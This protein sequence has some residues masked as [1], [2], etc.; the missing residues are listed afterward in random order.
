[1]TRN[2]KILIGIGVVLILGALAFANFKFK[3][4]EG[5]EVNVEAI[6]RRH[7]EAIVSASGKIQPQ[8]SVNISA[9]TQGRVTNLAVDEGD[10]VK[11]GQFL[12]QIDP[13]LLKSAVDQGRASLQAA[14]STIEQLKVAAESAKAAAAQAKLDYDRQR[15]LWQRGLTT[16]EA[17][18]SANSTLKM[19]SA[20]ANSAQGQVD[21]QKLRASQEAA[22]LESAEY[23]LSKVRIQS[24]IDG[25]VTRRNIEEGETVVVGTMNNA[26]TQLLTIADMSIIEAQVEVD[27]TDIPTVAIGQPAKVTIDAMPGKT[28]TGKVIEIGNSPIQD[29]TTGA[30]TSSTTQAT[31]FLVKVMLDHTIPDVR[32]GFT[33]TAEITTAT[34]ENALSVP[35]QA[36]TV[37]EMIVDKAGHIV[38]DPQSKGPGGVAP[39]STAVLPPGQS[40]KEFEGVFV[41]RDNKAEF[42]PVKTGIAGDKYFEVLSGLKEGDKVITGPFSSVR[43]LADN[44][45]VKV[46]APTR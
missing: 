38:R 43:D 26:G 42:V 14:R 32:P 29:T 34:R 19:R 39:A 6:T 40:R 28:F 22:A 24:P 33:C 11:K 45:P 1:M 8:R 9:D 4:T 27:E 17:L 30:N 31:N 3:R 37:R 2:K 21:T 16:K 13:R 23:S 44:A 46:A 35:I 25:I 18:D 15:E 10:R 41:V 12:M 36:T 5:P 7:L 20:D